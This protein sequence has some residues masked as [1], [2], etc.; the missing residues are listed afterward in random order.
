M[1]KASTIVL[2]TLLVIALLPQSGFAA[3]RGTKV[4]RYKGGL[5]FPIDMA[6]VPGTKT[7]FFTEKTGR[8]RVMHG[9]KLVPR[10]CARLNVASDGERGLLGIALHPKYKRNHFLYAFYVN[11]SPLQSRVARFKVI[12]NRCRGPRLIVKNIPASSSYHIGGQ[13]EF[14]GGNLFVSV[15]EGHDSGNA[16]DR[17]SRLGKILRYKPDGSIPRGNPFS[18]S[19]NRNPVWSYGHRNGFGLT[20]KPGTRKLFE[21]ENGPECDD[22]LNRIKKGRN[23][24]WG[25]GYSCG[26]GGVGPRPKGPL[27][28]WSAVIAVTDPWWY[29]GRMKRLNGDIYAGGFSDGTLHR[30]VINA[31]GTKVRRDRVIHRAE[32]VVDVSKGPKGWL[33]FL[34]ASG[35]YRIV[36]N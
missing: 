19:G 2:M 33:Y 26:P 16:Q 14:A 5:D 23:Y 18:K 6:W 25:S 24:G 34:T 10:P 22:E 4:T 28:R 27:H 31:K 20:H 13:I 32:G 1:R 3:P 17:S 9:R 11:A 7:T 29:Q 12:G 21:T 8:I 36:P 30:L 35:M 15:G